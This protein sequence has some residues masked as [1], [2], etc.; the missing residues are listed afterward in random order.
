M[1]EYRFTPSAFRHGITKETFYECFEDPN[2]LVDRSKAG[3]YKCIAQVPSGAILHVAFRLA[4]LG[5]VILVFHGLPADESE[6]RRYRRR[7]K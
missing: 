6:V 5:K 7:G 4:D 2:R 3:S 1:R